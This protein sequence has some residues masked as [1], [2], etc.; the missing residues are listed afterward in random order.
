MKD[1]SV[2][3]DLAAEAGGNIETTV[4]GELSVH[5]VSLASLVS[6][7]CVSEKNENAACHETHTQRLN[8]VHEVTH[9]NQSVLLLELVV[10]VLVVVPVFLYHTSTTVTAISAVVV[11]IKCQ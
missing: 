5:K 11:R 8:I 3:V 4:P 7:L 10:L 9:F 1:G 2:V 6:L